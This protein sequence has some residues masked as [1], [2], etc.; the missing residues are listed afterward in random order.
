MLHCVDIFHQG[1]REQ[2]VISALDSL[3][4]QVPRENLQV[5]REILQI[6]R[7]KFKVPREKLQENL[8][9]RTT[10]RAK[11]PYFPYVSHRLPA[12]SLLKYTLGAGGVF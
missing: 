9:H 2:G 4:L 8:E 1:V 10:K 6:S 5:S 12:R 11:D 7:E 3:G